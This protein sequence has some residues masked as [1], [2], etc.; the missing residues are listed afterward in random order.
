[1]LMDNERSLLKDLKL[2]DSQAITEVHNLFFADVY[3]YA[4]YRVGDESKA[5]DIA[6]ET[7]TRMIE[8]FHSQKVPRSSL[9]GW[10]MGTVS[11]IVNDYFRM[12]YARPISE[13]SDDIEDLNSLPDSS[14]ERADQNEIIHAALQALTSEQQHVL[15]LRFGSGYSLDETAGIMSK[16]PNAIKQLQFRALAA[17]RRQLGDDFDV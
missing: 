8:A 7:F 13:L 10:L 9:R 15:A 4:C 1:M 6:S 16:K 11:N 5:E 3:R 2:L 14:A 12:V 17:L